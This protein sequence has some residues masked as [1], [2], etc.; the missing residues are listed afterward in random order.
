MSANSA[1]PHFCNR[2]LGRTVGGVEETTSVGSEQGGHFP[3]FCVSRGDREAGSDVFQCL[4]ER[5]DD[6][7]ERCDDDE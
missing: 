7:D 2:H 1:P 4:V 3:P 5:S 6:D